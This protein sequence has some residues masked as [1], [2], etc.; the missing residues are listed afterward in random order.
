[1]HLKNIAQLR[2]QS[3][4][5]LGHKLNTPKQVVQWMGAMQAQ[6]HDMAKWA[7]G[8][9][10]EGFNDK[11]IEKSLEDGS[12]VRTHA[13]RP[14][15]H[16]IAGEDIRWMLKLSEPGIKKSISYTCRKMG[17]NEKV[18]DQCNDIIAKVLSGNNHLT[19]NELSQELQIAGIDID[20]YRLGYIIYYAETTGVMC[21]GT[22]KGKEITYALLDE[23]VPYVAPLPR[24]EALAKL[25]LRYFTSHGPA[26]LDDFT[27]WSGLSKGNSRLALASIQSN[28]GSMEIGDITF[29]FS[30]GLLDVPKQD[31]TYLLPAFDELLVSYKERSPSLHSHFSKKVVT[32]NGIFKPIIAINGKVIGIW[33]RTITKNH[34]LLEPDYFNSSDK[35]NKKEL[36]E[37]GM[38]YGAFMDSKI[39][40]A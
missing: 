23:K 38:K 20:S 6:N 22:R 5:L 26:T 33:K 30:P 14:T 4:L 2:L 32:P 36:L 34:I 39:R 31:T 10:L 8:V 13:P 28:L 24:E 9:R 15:W 3:Q 27:W 7:V 21:N 12:I 11:E 16:L 40:L 17:L 25:A 37:A 18:F 29:W 19:R 1:M 35:L